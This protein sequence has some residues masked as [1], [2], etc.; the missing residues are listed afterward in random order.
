MHNM[1]MNNREIHDET[2]R[3]E[4]TVGQPVQ[5]VVSGVLDDIFHDRY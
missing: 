4:R 1:K 3:V 2:M 5:P